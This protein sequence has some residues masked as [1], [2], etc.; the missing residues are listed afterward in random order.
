MVGC[1]IF[2]R[3]DTVL[4]SKGAPVARSLILFFTPSFAI[5]GAP[6]SRFG[7]DSGNT[8]LG[9]LHERLPRS[10]WSE[11]GLM[12]DIMLSGYFCRLR[13]IDQFA[14]PRLGMMQITLKRPKNLALAHRAG[15]R[16]I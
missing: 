13:N 9:E 14:W 7:S 3:S 8:A 5:A 4:K 12:I 2:D 15:S 1:H 10:A 6:R 16:I 11:K